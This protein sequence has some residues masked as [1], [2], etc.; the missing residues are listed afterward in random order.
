MPDYRSLRSALHRD[1]TNRWQTKMCVEHIVEKFC[2]ASENNGIVTFTHEDICS[3]E[4]FA[5]IGDKLPPL[6]QIGSLVFANIPLSDDGL[7]SIVRAAEL[8]RFPQLRILVLSGTKIS[9]KGVKAFANAAKADGF[10]QLQTLML[11]HTQVGDA[12]VEAIAHAVEA[13]R[14]PQLQALTLQSRHLGNNGVKTLAHA[15]ERH[16]LLQLQML[17]LVY[18]SRFLGIAM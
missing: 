9:N 15:A 12:G 1:P 14:L 17:A 4:S 8:F 6:P 18:S 11:D 13:G 2:T 7:K 3:D 16:S 5:G 10:L